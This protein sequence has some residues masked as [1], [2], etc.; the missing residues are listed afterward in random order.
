MRGPG[1]AGSVILAAV[2][3][4]GA[5]TL[6]NL[7]KD[8]DMARGADS[9]GPVVFSHQAHVDSSRPS[10]TGCHPRLFAMGMKPGAGPV[11]VTHAAMEKKQYCGACHDG[12]QASGFDDCTKCHRSN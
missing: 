12:E 5:G 10:C 9:P 1:R 2:L 6:P 11:K 8:K 4:V 3:A 7:P